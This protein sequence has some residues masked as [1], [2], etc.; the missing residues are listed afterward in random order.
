MRENTARQLLREAK[1]DELLKKAENLIDDWQKIIKKEKV[2]EEKKE[3]G[4]KDLVWKFKAEIVRI[5]QD[6]DLKV[7]GFLSDKLN[8][9]EDVFM[10]K[11]I[12]LAKR[13][14]GEELANESDRMSANEA[15]DKL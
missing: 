15:L 5:V 11:I 2:E 14:V 4:L 6:H 3:F 13:K 12:D 9:A 10:L 7:N 1:I 8:K